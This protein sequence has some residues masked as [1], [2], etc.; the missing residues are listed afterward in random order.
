MSLD[1]GVWSVA[2]GEREGGGGSTEDLGEEG[3]LFW[4]ALTPSLSP[5]RS[6]A[7]PHPL[8][9][10]CLSLLCTASAPF[11]AAPCI[12][13]DLA[14][15]LFGVLP[16]DILAWLPKPP[17]SLFKEAIPKKQHHLQIIININ[18][19]SADLLSA[20]LHTRCF[21]CTGSAHQQHT[22]SS[23]P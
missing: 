23:F 12:L 14:V 13:P 4:A 9:T 10:V 18:N 6:A 8:H 21:M 5:A 22:G 20:R 17:P 7:D 11:L 16:L 19:V 2:Q 15:S 1:R 3:V